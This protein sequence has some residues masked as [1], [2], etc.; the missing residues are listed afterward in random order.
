MLGGA[1]VHFALAA[2]FFEDVC[3]VGP[4]GEDFGEEQIGVMTRRG[5]DVD[6]IERIPGGRTFFWRGGYGWDL[7]T[8]ETIDTPLGGFQ[9]VQP[10]L[11]G[12]ALGSG[13][14]LLA[15]LPPE[16]QRAGRA[17]LPHPRVGP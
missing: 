3:V 2:S 15:H 14:L 17:P 6:G 8:R 1:A 7:N 12:A 4:V 5:V 11:T 9:G 13:R 16:L 10:K